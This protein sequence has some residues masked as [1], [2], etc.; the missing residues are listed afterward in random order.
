[1]KHGAQKLI[2]P[3][4]FE[5]FKKLLKTVSA[6]RFQEEFVKLFTKSKSPSYGLKLMVELGMM[7]VLFSQVKKIDKWVLDKIGK[8]Y[9]PVFLGVLLQDYGKQAGIVAQKTM[10]VFFIIQ[11][12]I[13]FR[14][15]NVLKF[16]NPLRWVKSSK[17][18]GR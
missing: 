17:N 16:K 12:H 11:N 9:F 10:K 8:A 3:I 7:K 5:K 2:S 6:E 14:N 4:I 1:M 18:C 13:F 15:L